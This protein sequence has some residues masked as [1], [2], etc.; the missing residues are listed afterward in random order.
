MKSRER[1]KRA[2]HFKGPDRVPI[3]HAILPAAQIKYGQALNDILDRVHEDFGWDFQ[4]DLKRENFPPLYKLGRN[5]DDFGTLWSVEHEGICGIPIGL[6]LEDWSKYESFAWPE[7]SAGP[8]KARQYSGHLAG[9]NEE[10][11]AR[12][13]WITTFEQMQQLRG[14]ENLLIDIAF[15]SKE[16]HRLRDD[17]LQFNLT[18][19]DKWTK[20][21]YDGLHFADDWGTQRA[22]MIDPA[23]WRSFFK[24]MYRAMF[25]KVR[26]AGMDVHFHSDG[27]IIDIIPDL[28]DLGV[29]VLNCQSTV[30]GL[31]RLKKDFAGKMCFRTDLDRQRVMPFGSPADVK[32]HILDMFAHLGTPDGGI[33]ACGEI[34]PD[35]P[36][37]NI[38]AMYEGFRDYYY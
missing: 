25:E 27:Q 36:I 38:R 16:I 33:I 28:L 15:D 31:E 19:L 29:H 13:A 26:A 4:E 2:I 14:M 3:S 12:G 17:M 30:I 7:F 10:Y 22:L 11:Y 21:E 8:P 24:P 5:Y 1:V 34:G 37:E 20:L 23:K 9:F 6:P 32:E 35:I 18:W